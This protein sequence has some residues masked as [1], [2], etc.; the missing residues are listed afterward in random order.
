MKHL[1]GT[2]A[3]FTGER[4]RKD[5]IVFEALGSTD[6]LTSAIGW[7]EVFNILASFT[8]GERHQEPLY[9][10]S[11]LLFTW[12]YPK[13][14]AGFKLI[15]PSPLWVWIPLGILDSFMWGSYPASLQNVSGSTLVPTCTWN[16]ARIE[17]ISY[18]WL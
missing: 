18:C 11:R 5:D 10:L 14:M 17:Q 1:T 4:R 16:N 15:F 13:S 12:K 6:E 9:A 2:S 3:T 7:V 8:G